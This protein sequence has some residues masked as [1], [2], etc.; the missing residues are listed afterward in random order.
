MSWRRD[1]AILSRLCVLPLL[2]DLRLSGL[3]G[4]SV[5]PGLGDL[6]LSSAVASLALAL[7]AAA[8]AACPALGEV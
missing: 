6:R 8:L 3:C 1:L 5:L 7:A 4:L 2:R